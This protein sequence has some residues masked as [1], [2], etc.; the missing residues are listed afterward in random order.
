MICEAGGYS[1]RAT[2]TLSRKLKV[3]DYDWINL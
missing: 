2:H 3:V 1:G